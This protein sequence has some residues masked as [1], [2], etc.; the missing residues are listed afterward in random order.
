MRFSILVLSLLTIVHTAHADDDV[1][2]A[3]QYQT[4]AIQEQTDEIV[5]QTQL[6]APQQ[7][8][9]PDERALKL[10]AGCA[11]AKER[12]S[13]QCTSGP[14]NKYDQNCIRIQ[15]LYSHYCK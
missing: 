10:A 9:Q 3:I 15:D 7:A 4:D 13:L 11:Q 8:P 1:V 5:L 14:W 6:M 12:Y 2:E